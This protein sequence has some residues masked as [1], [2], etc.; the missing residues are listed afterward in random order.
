MAVAKEIADFLNDKGVS[1]SVFLNW[2][3]DQS[4]KRK[5]TAELI[6][7]WLKEEGDDRVL[8]RAHTLA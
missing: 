7:R 8:G 3:G 2:L 6:R 5:L 1:R 4:E